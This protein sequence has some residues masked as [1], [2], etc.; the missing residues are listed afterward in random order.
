MMM[1]ISCSV[2][3]KCQTAFLP[4]TKI[5]LFASQPLFLPQFPFELIRLWGLSFNWGISMSLRSG[6]SHRSRVI[7]PDCQIFN[8]HFFFQAWELFHDITHF[9]KQHLFLPLFPI[10]LV[11]NL[12][13]LITYQHLPNL[14]SGHC[15]KLFSQN[16]NF[17]LLG[18]YIWLL[19]F[20]FNPSCTTPQ[21]NIVTHLRR[22]QH[23]PCLLLL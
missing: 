11:T 10:V 15:Q 21:T 22:L 16:F 2:M 1:M 8:F 13:T 9:L 14:I 23:F 18:N 5:P 6:A 19:N 3:I 17:T 20:L 7:F 12:I 4:S